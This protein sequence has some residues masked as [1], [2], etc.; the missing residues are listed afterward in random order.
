MVQLRDSRFVGVSIFAN[1][2]QAS[3]LGSAALIH[4]LS[5]TDDVTHNLTVDSCVFRLVI[6]AFSMG[7]GGGGSLAVLLAFVNDFEIVT[8]VFMTHRSWTSEEASDP[9]SMSCKHALS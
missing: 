4:R 1:A 5:R 3:V 6:A 9:G 7:H 2:L 8:H